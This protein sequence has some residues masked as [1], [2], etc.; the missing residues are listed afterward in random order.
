MVLKPIII[1]E[2]SINLMEPFF[3]I[4]G[5]NKIHIR[6]IEPTRITYLG[7]T[8]LAWKKHTQSESI[9]T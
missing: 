5:L 3:I 7:P 1:C 8:T 4:V 2:G 6:V 9:N